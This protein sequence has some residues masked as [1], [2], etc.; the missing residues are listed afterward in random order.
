VG[1]IIHPR[2]VNVDSA[3]SLVPGSFLGLIL[4]LGGLAKLFGFWSWLLFIFF[5]PLISVLAVLAFYDLVK[6]IFNKQIALISSVLL[7][8]QPAFWY[9][10]V[11]GLLPNVLFVDLLILGAW[12][13]FE[14]IADRPPA[15]LC[16]AMRAGCSLFAVYLK[17][18]LSGLLIG[19]ALT[20]RTSEAIWVGVVIMGLIIVYRKKVNWLAL[21][22]FLIMIALTFVPV[23]IWNYQ[24]YGGYLNSGYSNLM[25]SSQWPVANSQQLVVSELSAIGYRL[26]AIFPF[27]F[28]P[29]TALINFWHYYIKMLWWYFVPMIVGF[30]WFLIEAVR[31]SGRQAVK[32]KEGQAV[33]YQPNSLSAYQ[34]NHWIYLFIFAFVTDWLIIY[35]GSWAVRDNISGHYTLGTSY[36][37][38]WL[39]AFILG[40]PLI[41][42]L[43][44]KILT[45]FKEKFSRVLVGI[46]IFGL[47]LILSVNLVVY[48][49]E[50]LNQIQSEVYKYK[51]IN[52]IARQEL[53]PESIIISDRSDKIFWPE[54][55]VAVFLGDFTVF[56]KLGKVIDSTPVYYYSH[57]QLTP[58]NLNYLNSKIEGWGLEL[59]WWGS[60][61]GG[62]GLYKLKKK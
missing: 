33:A 4:I 18:I 16:V 34:F 54:F 36:L 15:T 41:A 44:V 61:S 48:S 55:R 45:W 53:D 52:Q 25:A 6:K 43:I 29:R 38:Y 57:N 51:I 19:L 27:G 40:L 20:V 32:L 39:P 30:V 17:Y 14:Q 7:F 58:E 13:V 5:I 11:R 23:L 42:W 56:E 22:L 3:G 50:G 8:L 1:N 24:L 49:E 47:F 12:V 46:F 31:P 35:Y 21:I 60:L 59:E 9:Y 37:R 28:H 62:D 2:S 26:S 10:T